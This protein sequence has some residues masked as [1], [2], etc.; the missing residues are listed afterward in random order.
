MY[1]YVLDNLIDIALREMY[2]DGILQ[3]ELLPYLL[4]RTL[5]G[6]TQEECIIRLPVECALLL[7]VAFLLNFSF[8]FI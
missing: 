2:H 7:H 3:C 8:C 4:E 1:M 5:Q 6:T